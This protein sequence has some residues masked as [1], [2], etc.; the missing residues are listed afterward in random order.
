MPAPTRRAGS[1]FSTCCGARRPRQPLNGVIVAFGADMLSRLDAGRPRRATPRPCAAASRTSR[2]GSDS[3][4]R[5]ISSSARSTS[6]SASP[7]S[8]T[9]STGRCA[10]QVWGMTFPCRAARRARL[11]RF[12][13]RVL[14]RWSRACRTGSWSVCRRSAVRPSG[15]GSPAFRPS[16]P[17]SK[18]V[19][20]PFVR[21]AFGGSQLDPA[22]FLRGV[23]FTSGTQEGTP[24]D[25]LTG[26]LSR[27]FGLAPRRPTPARPQAGRSYF[28]GR[29]LRDVVFN[30]A[31]LAARDRN[32]DRR[33]LA[34]RVGVWS[35]AG[36]LRRRRR[37]LG[38]ISDAG[39]AGANRKAQG[40]H[41][42]IAG[43]VEGAGLRSRDRCRRP[44][45]AC[46]P[47]STTCAVCRTRRRRH[48]DLR[49]RPAGQ[50]R[51]G[52]P[53]RSTTTRS[54]ASSAAPPRPAG[55][56]DAGGLQKPDYLYEATRVYLMLGREGQLD[57]GLVT[58]WMRLDW[59][60]LFPGAVGTA[61]RDSLAAH[62]QSL[63]DQDFAKYPLDESVVAEARIVFSKLTMAER[64]YGRLSAARP[65]ERQL[66]RRRRAGAGG[67]A[68]VRHR[69]GQGSRRR[70]RPRPLYRRWT[71]EELPA[72]ASGRDRRRRLRKLAAR[73]A[74]LGDGRRSAPA[75][76][77]GARSLCQRLCAA[78]AMA[79]ADIAVQPFKTLK[80]AS[81]GL[82]VLSAPNSPIR[83]LLQSA[84]KQSEPGTPPAGA[85]LLQNAGKA[86]Q[87]AAAATGAA[88][89][90]PP[91]ALRPPR[92]S[93]ACPASS[94][95]PCRPIPR[96]W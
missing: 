27:T 79:L 36:L 30:E 94:A 4:F 80:Q 67:L 61:S 32:R 21:T 77:R 45:I 44:P 93:P 73:R 31:R 70:R 41:G 49:D 82:N 69:L 15:R 2:T 10:R 17:R 3:G 12:A 96:G 47:I 14:P 20:E 52:G 13:R 60:E 91:R 55:G 68:M 75:R 8:S 58:E 23:Y 95:Q 86:I 51:V 18:P 40:G 76:G 53:G 64:V 48:D 26:A 11:G 5:S 59:N 33:R 16:S 63:L 84:A 25:R 57:K 90:L 88:R 54:T 35:L 72:A 22:P 65:G 78:L 83:D 74:E 89:R 81:D 71:A 62:L 56:P 85:T 46:F 6:S 50:A 66:A 24:I 1:G 29:L 43:C 34:I 92:G 37:R 28:L 9:T 39:R 87:G 7:S 38:V 19:L 42:G